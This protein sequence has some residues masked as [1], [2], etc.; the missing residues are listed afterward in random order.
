MQTNHIIAATVAGGLI[1]TASV[2]GLSGNVD[3][4][5]MPGGRTVEQYSADLD[6]MVEQGIRYGGDRFDC[7]SVR[8]SNGFSRDE[9]LV[10]CIN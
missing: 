7:L 6:W 9:A 8:L 1:L 4:G 2:I 10:A 5:P 3:R